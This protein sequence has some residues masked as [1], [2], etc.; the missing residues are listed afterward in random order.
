MSTAQ[1][2][3][4]KQKSFINTLL[5]ERVDVIPN[6]A[7]IRGQIDSLTKSAASAWINKLLD[8]PKPKP[9]QMK[10]TVTPEVPAGSYAL[11]VQGD[12]VF[13]QVDR[14]TKGKWNG[15]TFLS[16]LSG[17]NREPIKA[18]AEK[19]IVL[20]ALANDLV[21]AARRYG[22]Y[23]KECGFCHI[24]LTDAFS[25][26]YGVGPVCRKHHGMPISR[27]AYV[28]DASMNEVLELESW[29]AEDAR[30]AWKD[31]HARQEFAAEQ[32]AYLSEMADEHAAEMA[33]AARS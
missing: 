17:D 26:F 4:D 25:R 13:Y 27:A 18:P 5:D 15:Y 19:L 12:A 2:A 24:N 11:D 1:N 10:L 29:E 31:E 8:M 28:R 16:R 33:E 23:R 6:V 20:E 30:I 14:P 3:S 21:A 22:H 9:T 7:E 32:Q